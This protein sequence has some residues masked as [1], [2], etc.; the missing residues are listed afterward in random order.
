MNLR[1]KFAPPPKPPKIFEIF[2]KFRNQ[3]LKYFQSQKFFPSKS[4]RGGAKN[5]SLIRTWWMKSF[6]FIRNIVEQI[7]FFTHLLLFRTG[8]SCL[9]SSNGCCCITWWIGG[10]CIGTVGTCVC[11][12]WLGECMCCSCSPNDEL[13]AFITRSFKLSRR[14]LFADAV[15]YLGV[16][17]RDDTGLTDDSAI[18]SEGEKY[19]LFPT[20]G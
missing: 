5:D 13:C 20:L 1:K 11:W 8:N 6:R 17:F 15:R 12:E 4:S 7:L 18:M 9:F 19:G 2:R 16:M 10:D 14:E 3:H